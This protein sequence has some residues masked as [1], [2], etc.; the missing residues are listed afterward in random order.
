[1]HTWGFLKKWL[2]RKEKERGSS[3]EGIPEITGVGFSKRDCSLRFAFLTIGIHRVLW[4]LRLLSSMGCQETWRRSLDISFAVHALMSFFRSRLLTFLRQDLSV[5]WTGKVV[6]A[7]GWQPRTC[8]SPLPC[9]YKLRRKWFSDLCSDTSK[10]CKLYKRYIGMLWFQQ[11]SSHIV[12]SFV[13][14]Y[15]I[16][17]MLQFQLLC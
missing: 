11:L 8:L 2:Y 17:R 5:T 14:S 3:K 6:E 7:A 15:Q 10:V 4:E 16:S 12:L 1:M 13:V 9:F